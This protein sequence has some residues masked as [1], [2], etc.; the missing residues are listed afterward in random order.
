MKLTIDP[1][2]RHGLTGEKLRR[3]N[4][5][6]R[7]RKKTLYLGNQ[8]KRA[9]K[10]FDKSKVYFDKGLKVNNFNFEKP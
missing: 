5:K 8:A 1:I 6:K 4:R 9:S 7:Q 2:R 10:D 3:Q